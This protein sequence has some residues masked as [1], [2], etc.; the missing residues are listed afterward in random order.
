[1]KNAVFP[2]LDNVYSVLALNHET[3]WDDVSVAAAK[4]NT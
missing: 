2:D 3:F 4:I 1:L